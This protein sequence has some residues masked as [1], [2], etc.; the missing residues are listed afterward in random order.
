MQHSHNAQG[1]ITVKYIRVADIHL[2]RALHGL[3]CD[4]GVAF[5]LIAGI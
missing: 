2:D 4:E 3:E 1:D 5:M